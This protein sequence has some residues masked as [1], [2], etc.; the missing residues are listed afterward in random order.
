[1]PTIS[2]DTLTFMMKRT[3]NT[4]QRRAVLEA[5]RTLAEAGQ[6]PTAAEVFEQV[7]LGY[8]HL[9]L[10]TVYRAL[11]ALAEQGEIGGPHVET[12][13]HYDAN[14]TPHHHAVCR[15]CGKMEDIFAT[16]PSSAVKRLKEASMFQLDTEMLHLTGVCPDCANRPAN[17]SVE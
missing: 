3:R 13:A 5:V 8:P 9:S 16:L 14:P 17:D 2:C 12:H 7:R 15:V 11:H 4:V 1:M 10:A 6:H